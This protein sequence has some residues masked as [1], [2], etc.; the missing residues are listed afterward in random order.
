MIFKTKI[1]ASNSSETIALTDIVLNLFVFFFITF[2]LS[3]SFGGAQKGTLAIDLPKAPLSKIGETDKLLTLLI[4]RNGKIYV[5]PRMI[6]PAKLK[7]TLNQEL[8]LRKDKNILIQADRSIPLQ[9][10][11][12]ILDIVKTTKARAVAIETKF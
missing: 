7:L 10:F 3:A 1:K 6:D 9:T 2:G 11:I 5:G 12:S 4:D 8:Y